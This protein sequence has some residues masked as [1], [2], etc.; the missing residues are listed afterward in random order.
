MRNCGST[1]ELPPVRTC[2]VF[3]ATCQKASMNHCIQRLIAATALALCRR[4]AAPAHRFKVGAIDIGHPYAR[5]H[6]RGPADRRRLHEAHQ[7]G[8]A[9]IAC[10]RPRSPAAASVELHSMTMD[11]DVMK[12]RQV[13]AIDLPAGQ[14]VELKPGGYHLMLIGLKAPLKAGDKFP[15]T[16]KF[17]KA[18]EVIVTVKVEKPSR[19]TPPAAQALSR[20]ADRPAPVQPSDFKAS[21]MPSLTRRRPAAP[22]A[23]RRLRGRCSRA[24]PAPAG[25]RP[26]RRSATLA[27]ALSASPSLPLSSSSSRSAVFLPMPGTFTRR[28]GFLQAH[29]LRQLVDAQARQHR[30]RHARADA[31]DLDQQAE[32]LRARRG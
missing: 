17:E 25:C 12:M 29:R 4:V 7:P 10:C 27:G 23:P 22:S 30:Q 24:R 3:H 9:P 15:L 14:T 13:D 5:A 26:A 8:R 2:T 16:L 32:G 18:G 20:R 6:R 31:G 11:G 21:L 28:A 1:T 19:A